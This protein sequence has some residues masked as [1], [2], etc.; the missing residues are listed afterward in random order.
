MF[1]KTWLKVKASIKFSPKGSHTIFWP[2]ILISGFCFS[3]ACVLTL[4]GKESW[5]FLVAGFI[6]LF[7]V[8]ISWERTHKAV[9]N[10]SLQ[11]IIYSTDDGKTSTSLS[12]PPPVILDGDNIA[13]L[14]RMFSMMQHRSPLPDPDGLVDDSGN[15]IPMSEEEARKLV[16]AANNQVQAIISGVFQDASIPVNQPGIAQS[17]MGYEPQSHEIKDTNKPSDE[18]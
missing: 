5:P 16:E 4:D 12:L 2:L 17:R 3:L 10:N 6:T 8:F 9:D 7:F 15:P 1:S 13:S 18:S 14:E 11:P